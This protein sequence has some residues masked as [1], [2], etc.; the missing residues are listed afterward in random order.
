[1]KKLKIILVEPMSNSFLVKVVQIIGLDSLS[2]LFIVTLKYVY[3]SLE[4]FIGT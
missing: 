3:C 4:K 2:Q 1:M